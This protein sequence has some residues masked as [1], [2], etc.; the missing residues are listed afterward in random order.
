MQ[1][2]PEET[3]QTNNENDSQEQAKSLEQQL[4]D[5][6][7]KSQEYME[8]WKRAQAEFTNIK[9]RLEQEKQDFCKF[10][11]SGLMLSLLPIL[12]D[13]ELALNH[14]PREHE[15]SNWVKGMKLVYQKF[16]S[17]LETQGLTRIDSLGK[18]FDPCIHEAIKTEKGI[19]GMVIQEYQKGYMFNDRLLR[20]AKVIVG[21]G[22][23]ENKPNESEEAA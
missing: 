21:C 1:D 10:A 4:D 8:G 6:I 16:K 17:T 18:S 12:D 9:K 11:N 22:E 5:E 3:T 20:P 15:D 14:T 2:N 7:K 13:F 23:G 19:E